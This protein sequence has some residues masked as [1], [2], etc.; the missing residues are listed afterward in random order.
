[1][2]S[3][4]VHN[5]VMIMDIL[6]WIWGQAADGTNPIGWFINSKFPQK[7]HVEMVGKQVEVT[8]YHSGAPGVSQKAMHARHPGGSVV[9]TN[10]WFQ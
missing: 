3:K 7:K 5:Y 10:R 8:S 1:M 2:S 9:E 6:G 4:R